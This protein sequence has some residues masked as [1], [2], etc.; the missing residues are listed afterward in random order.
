[1][2]PSAFTG[3]FAARGL[4]PPVVREALDS[5]NRLARELAEQGAPHGQAVIALK[6]T[7]GR[8]RLGRSWLSDEHGSLCLSVVLRPTLRLARLPSVVLAAGVAL[9]ETC[10]APTRLKW[11]NDLVGPDRRKVAG[12]LAEAEAPGGRVDSLILG[13]GVNLSSAPLGLPATHLAALTGEAPDRAVLAATLTESLLRWS[14]IAASD[15]AEV[16]RAWLSYDLTLGRR[17]RVGAVEGVAVAL[18]PDGSL[19]LRE[20]SGRTHRIHAG[21]VEMIATS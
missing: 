2:S 4:L 9:A 19:E 15:P 6:Q 1:M 18:G 10:G 12:V 3:A 20:D 16:L 14:D 13:L 21:D 7:A 17:V 8:G 5:T 11:P